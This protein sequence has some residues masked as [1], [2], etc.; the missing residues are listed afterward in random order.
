MRT[1]HVTLT[2]KAPLLMHHDNV[3]WSDFMDEWKSNPAHK[4]LSKAGDDRSPPW[5]WLGCVYHDGTNL[6]I[7]QANVMR[8]LMEGGTMVLV[9]GGRMGKT[10]KAQTQSGMM[11]VEPFWTLMIGDSV[12]A[13]SDLEAFKD[14]E[15]FSEHREHARALGFDLL[16]KRAKI[17][18]S[19]HIRV[20]PQFATGW[21]AIGSLVVWDEQ[22]TIESLRS[23]I[24]YAGQYKGLGDWR[25]G[26]KT[27][28]PYGT[29]EG[30]IA[31][32]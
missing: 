8:A 30:K 1:Y 4:K 25:P 9:P 24:E 5:R 29:F 20:R 22:I 6:A 13:W 16:V 19:K 12:L 11:S 28:G 32:A 15:K 31:V 21:Q 3:E 7:P 17:G 14:L 10:F 18:Q 2:G 26:G 27:P 23:I